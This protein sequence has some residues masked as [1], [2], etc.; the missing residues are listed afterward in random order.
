MGG[1]VV[2][3]NVF[4]ELSPWMEVQLSEGKGTDR[5]CGVCDSTLMIIVIRFD[6]AAATHPAHAGR[7]Q[8][9]LI[10]GKTH[11]ARPTPER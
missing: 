5:L 9:S 1:L 6:C 4:F 2:Q 10:R 7:I 11:P 8:T 3:V